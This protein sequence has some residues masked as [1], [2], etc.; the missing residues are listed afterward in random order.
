MNGW[1]TETFSFWWIFPLAMCILCFLMMRGKKIA[2]LCTF[3]SAEGNDTS[4]NGSD[5][6]IE[7][8]DKRYAL[9]EINKEEYQAM[10][11]NI[12]HQRDEIQQ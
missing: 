7:I 9:G 10:K 6:A 5:S 4:E 12:N 8:L 3:G 11:K 2:R 1:E